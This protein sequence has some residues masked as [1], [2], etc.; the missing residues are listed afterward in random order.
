MLTPPIATAISGWSIPADSIRRPLKG[1]LSLIRQQSQLA[2][3]GGRHSGPP[4][5]CSSR[6]HAAD[7]EVVATLRGSDKPVFY[8]INKVDTPKADPLVADFY[9]LGQEHL[10]PLSAE[11]GIGVAEIARRFV[12]PY[13]RPAG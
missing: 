12:S 3:A 10:Y 2:I 9:R 4:S 11:H 13:G 8:V 6:T 5:R 1:M 7:E